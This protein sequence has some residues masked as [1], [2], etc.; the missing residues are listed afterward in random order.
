MKRPISWS[1]I[2]TLDC[3]AKHAFGYT[4]HLTDGAALRRKVSKRKM[5]EGKA[6]GG[7]VA[8]Y[9]AHTGT[10]T[11]RYAHGLAAL[12]HVLDLEALELAAQ[13]LYDPFDRDDLETRLADILWHYATLTDPLALQQ[14]ELELRVPIRSRTGRRASTLYEFHG[15]VDGLVIDAHGIWVYEAKLRDNLFSLEQIADSRQTRFYAAA[16]QQQLGIQV[17]GVIVDE[18]RNELPKPARWVKGRKKGD[19]T[20][21]SHA[22]DQLTTPESYLDACR[23]AGVDPVEE[24]LE[25]LTSR[26]W[27]AR[28]RLFYSQA[29]LADAAAEL[30]AGAQLVAML[31]S[32]RLRPFR[33]PSPT[34]CAMCPFRGAVCRDPG[35]H[36]LIDLDYERVPPKR[37]RHEEKE[38]VAA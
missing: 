23:E 32:G 22:T 12:R 14:P 11:A 3:T 16:V 13:G 8:A 36:D 27:Q 15:Y 24:T 33:N 5:R 6:W 1:E 38:P 20:V 9:H 21:P 2:Q 25:A 28:H 19:G 26:R 34:R 31:D 4:G 17:V 35:D 10:N 18:R 29:E 7:A 37:L 30:T